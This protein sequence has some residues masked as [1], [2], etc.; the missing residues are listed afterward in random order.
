MTPDRFE[1]VQRIF[2]EAA[3]TDAAARE[4]LLARR[5]AGD[6]A[7]LEEVRSLL[8][9]QSRG[10]SSF[11]D[12]EEVRRI[13]RDEA[14]DDP[15]LPKGTRLGDYTIE[16]VLGH[17]GMG[18]VYLAHQENPRRTVALKV[19]RASMF[20]SSALRRFEHEAQVLGMLQHPGIAQI[21]EAGAAEMGR[22]P[23]PYIAMELVDGPT[24]LKHA[25]QQ[26][27]DV[28]GRLELMAR[29]CDAVHHAHQRGVIH[30]DLKPGNILVDH[31]GQPK[32]L[33]FGVSRAADPDLRATINTSAGQL[34]GTLSYMSP[35][36]A[37]GDPEQIDVRSDVYSL[38]VVLFELLSGQLPYDI[39]TK[40]IPEAARILHD[41]E[42]RRLGSVER[43]LRGELDLIAGKALERDKSRRYQSAAELADDIRAHLAGAPIS[44]RQDSALYVLSKFVRRHALVSALAGAFV[45]SV[46][47]LG[48]YSTIQ[49]YRAGE[50]ARAELMERLK[51]QKALEL[52][53]EQTQRAD[54]AADDAVRQL[55]ASNIE[56]GRLI[57]AGGSMLLAED[58]IW[59]ALLRD[60]T[61]AH[62][63][64][65]LWELY[66][67]NPCRAAVPTHADAV[68]AM[69]FS[70]DGRL[71]VTAG[72]NGYVELW[73]ARSLATL[74]VL[75][76]HPRAEI[77]AQFTPDGRRLVLCDDT[78]MVQV[79]DT[80]SWTCEREFDA[81]LTP[82]LWMDTSP[83][84]HT[85]IVAGQGGFVARW[86]LDDGA[87]LWQTRPHR[88]SVNSLAHAP[89]GEKIITGSSDGDMHIVST[90]DG[91][92]VDSLRGHRGWISGVDWSRDGRYIASGGSD[93]EVRVWDAAA[94]LSLAAF[95]PSNGS[96]GRVRFSPD[97]RY[98][99]AAGWWRLDVYDLPA[100]RT[101]ASYIGFK[102][103]MHTAR[104]SPAGDVIGTGSISPE[105][106]LWDLP[107]S[108]GPLRVP[109][110]AT[111]RITGLASSPDATRL[112]SYS[113][114]QEL[115][116]W[117]T[118]GYRPILRVT[119]GGAYGTAA[120]FI[121]DGSLFAYC[122]TA[123][124]VDVRWSSDGSPYCSLRPLPRIVGAIAPDP[125]GVHLYT[126]D[127]RQLLTR[128]NLL[129]G[130]P[131]SAADTVAMEGRD[132]LWLAVTRDGRRIDS[133]SRDYTL[134]SWS[135]PGFAKLQTIATVPPVWCLGVSPD[136]RTAAVGNWA[137]EIEL[138]DLQDRTRLGVLDGHSQLIAGV[139]FSADGTRLLSASNDGTIKW[140]D[141]PDRRCL[142][143]LQ[144]P[145][146]DAVASTV[147]SAD[148]RTVVA[149]GFDGALYVWDLGRFD[150]H[151]AGNLQS[152]IN[153]Q[154]ARQS[155]GDPDADTAPLKAWAQR[156][157]NEAG[158]GP[159][160]GGPTPI[161]GLSG[162]GCSPSPG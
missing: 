16:R 17:G 73:D 43:R 22:G 42:A 148:G 135:L 114:G 93:R 110:A 45:V 40:T 80:A 46:S 113:I 39:R 162:S 71:M 115:T 92:V 7:L 25:A 53:N 1:L 143:T 57:G 150:R 75:T 103:G 107:D 67:K 119:G 13:A 147:L 125:D 98:L 146:G 139:Q 157:L 58:A 105:L 37:L 4:Q 50:S 117:N 44:A 99:L 154:K 82:A 24:L 121:G 104:F 81:L 79:Y 34:I 96:I 2:E 41:T 122:T 35:E 38:G 102:R 30:R 69:D 3:A 118:D 87:M 9:F 111:S 28:R 140:W 62:A 106:R 155:A 78:A 127:Q 5:C 109:G 66:A 149:G 91:A 70:P 142:L 151:I 10:G 19:L 59:P 23:Q 124:R 153:R 112:I 32:V 76:I 156:V 145:T 56:R 72:A 88:D 68:R 128:W 97:G 20:G 60:P 83:D 29:V 33:D 12:P 116:L 48:V 11:L 160:N 64:W 137:S 108:T 18:I 36:Q 95:N 161:G 144:P 85:L 54:R 138:W 8:E 49:A 120:C 65:A 31:A 52:A 77:A 14:V 123:G 61:S 134:Q 101:V 26:P 84:A 141:V 126:C 159:R 130:A 132:P 94:G 55:R 51:A 100:W 158:A 6:P 129:T 136:A 27:L 89:D 152:Q 133:T 74:G 86:R 15:P 21:F 63:F 131:D 47:V 90:R